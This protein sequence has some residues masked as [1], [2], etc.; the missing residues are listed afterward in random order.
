M[1]A[2]NTITHNYTRR[3][4]ETFPSANQ[5]ALRKV[6]QCDVIFGAPSAGCQGTGICKIAAREE[7]SMRKRDCRNTVAWM[8]PV[9]GGTGITLFFFRENLC[10]E[11]IRKHFRHGVLTVAEPCRVPH[12]LIRQLDLKITEIPPGRYALEESFGYYRLN[13][14]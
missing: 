13:L 9:A 12:S 6:L 7:R 1:T 11:L 8:A 2:F 14:E 5:Q 10:S 3:V 4:S